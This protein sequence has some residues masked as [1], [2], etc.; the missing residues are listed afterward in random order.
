[1]S[2]GVNDIT[3]I[4]GIIMFFIA[5]GTLL[6]FIQME[7]TTSTSN[8]GNGFHNGSNIINQSN[9]DVLGRNATYHS[10]GIGWWESIG[11]GFVSNALYDSTSFVSVLFSIVSMFFWTFGN[12]PFWIDMIVF[13]PMRIMLLFIIIRNIWPGGGA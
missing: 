1:M 7:F 10:S 11:L 6:P 8:P 12:I 2:G 4:G 13:M 5:V 9:I 3:I